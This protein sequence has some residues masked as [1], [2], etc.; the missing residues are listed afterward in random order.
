MR[1]LAFFLPLLAGCSGSATALPDAVETHLPRLACRFDPA[2]AGRIEGQV[3]WDGERPQVDPLVYHPIRIGLTPKFARQRE[4]ANPHA[5]AIAPDGGVARA[6]VYLRGVDPE[7]AR[8]WPHPAVQVRLRG[9]QIQVNSPVAR[10]GD[11]IEVM[12]EDPRFHF[13]YADGAACFGLPLPQPGSALS[14]R[15]NRPGHVELSSGAS[16]F[17]MRGHIFVDDHPYYCWTDEEGRFSLE[18]V[19]PGTYQV[20]AW[21]PNWR[22]KERHFNPETAEVTRLYYQPAV[23]VKQPVSLGADEVLRVDFRFHAALFD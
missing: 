13:V 14:R 20:I 6:V 9:Q 4:F 3:R 16:C 17:W 5:P 21:L 11:S 10:R 2:T 8:P 12:S 22:E 15:L 7:R 18:Q 19:P 1:K 23:Q